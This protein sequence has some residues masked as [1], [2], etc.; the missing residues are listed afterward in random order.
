MR[1]AGTGSEGSWSEQPAWSCSSSRP[2][3]LQIPNSSSDCP[4]DKK[5]SC[6]SEK[7]VAG[8]KFSSN[9]SICSSLEDEYKTTQ[10]FLQ[11]IRN[12]SCDTLFLSPL[13]FFISFMIAWQNS[14]KAPSKSFASIKVRAYLP[15]K[16]YR[17]MMCLNLRRASCT[18]ELLRQ[19]RNTQ[20]RLRA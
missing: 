14:T 5:A 11:I 17:H 2:Q 16:H 13:F 7:K 19:L 3:E 4:K 9:Y 10:S 8:C 20:A 12:A 1:R 6:S 15:L 18:I